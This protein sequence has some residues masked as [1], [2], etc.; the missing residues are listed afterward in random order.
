MYNLYKLVTLCWYYKQLNKNF[1]VNSL[2]ESIYIYI[3]FFQ[4]W[5]FSVC[6]NHNSKHN[7]L[8]CQVNKDTMTQC[9]AMQCNQLSELRFQYYIHSCLTSDVPH[10]EIPVATFD[11][12]DVEALCWIY[13]IDILTSQFLQDGRLAGIVQTQEEHPQLHLISGLEASQ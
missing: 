3:F 9:N 12:L 13:M 7:N 2:Q 8:K 6:G 11:A 1:Q 5:R 4:H 10:C